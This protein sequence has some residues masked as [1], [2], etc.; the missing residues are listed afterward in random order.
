MSPL[1]D[2]N[3]VEASGNEAGGKVDAS[4]GESAVGVDVDEAWA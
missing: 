2:A 1:A 4:V 3:T